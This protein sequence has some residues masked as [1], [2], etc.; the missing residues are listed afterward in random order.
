MQ[1]SVRVILV[2]VHIDVDGA[3]P[4]T[5]LQRQNIPGLTGGVYNG[6]VGYVNPKAPPAA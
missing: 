6:L 2:I 4:P 1:G 5:Q 3:A